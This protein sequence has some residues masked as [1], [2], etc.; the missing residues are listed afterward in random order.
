MIMMM[1]ITKHMWI[2]QGLQD[3]DLGLQKK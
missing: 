1:M 2:H 3:E